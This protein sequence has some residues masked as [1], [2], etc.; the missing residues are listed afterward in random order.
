MSVSAPDPYSEPGR[1]YRY[2]ARRQARG[3]GVMPPPRD[4]R[5]AEERHLEMLRLRLVEGLTLREVGERTGV[6]GGQVKQLLAA[7]FGVSSR[8]PQSATAAGEGRI[9]VPPGFV[10]VLLEIVEC[11]HG[12]GIVTALREWQELELRLVIRSD[13]PEQSHIARRNLRRV[14]AF[15]AA[16]GVH[17]EGV[18]SVLP[19]VEAMPLL[20]SGSLGELG[21]SAGEIQDAA[22]RRD[23]PFRWA[24]REPLGRQDATRAL[25][26]AIGWDDV[27]KQQQPVRVYLDIHRDAVLRA[28]RRE[29]DSQTGRVEDPDTPDDARGRAEASRALLE[30]LLAAI[31]GQT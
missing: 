31:G 8:K 12:A 9:S 3:L 28:V 11:G 2:A 20:R 23:Q 13:D 22:I 15:M 18:V 25:L 21:G 4:Y 7:Y 16:A 6:T 5:V 10:D 29:L 17:D 26:D 1:F 27:E 24:Y 30:T 19:P 14:R